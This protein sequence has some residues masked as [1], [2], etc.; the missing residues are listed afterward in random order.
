MTSVPLDAT[1]PSAAVDVMDIDVSIVS[2][3]ASVPTILKLICQNTGLGFAAVAK[4]TDHEWTACAVE[5]RIGFGLEAGGQLPLQTTLCYESRAAIQPIVVDRFSIDPTYRG[6]VTP[7]TYRLESYVSVPIVLS[8][9][10][11]FGNLCGIDRRAVR[12]SDAWTLDMFKVFASLIALQIEKAVGQ[13][14]IQEELA[15]EK[16]RGVLREEFIAVLGHDLRNPLSAVSTSSQLLEHHSDP[17]VVKIG[18]RIRASTRR[19]TLLIDD[20]MDYARTRLGSGIAV[21]T[22]QVSDL[23]CRLQEVVTELQ[24]SFPDHIIEE[25]LPAL[26]PVTCDPARV[27]QLLSNLLANALVHGANTRPIVVSAYLDKTD[28]VL[29][30]T[31][32]GD[33]IG[34]ETLAKVFEPYWRPETSAPGGGLGL[35]LY[36]CKQIVKGHRGSLEVRSTADEGT[37]FSARIPIAS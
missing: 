31:N 19:M 4:V 13:K 6:H 18:Q 12:V 7:E 20:V 23:E 29:T 22:M 34:P 25:R 3:L 24:T 5:D 8:N 37:C 17:A 36:I 1:S 35:G 2:Q 15:F 21:K 27:Q 30:V 9:G 16:A 28:L 32:H 14:Q 26:G 33:V 11:Y 10:F